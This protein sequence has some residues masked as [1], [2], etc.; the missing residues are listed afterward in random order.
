MIYRK[1]LMKIN[2]LRNRP[3]AKTTEPM[4]YFSYGMNTSPRVMAT[5]DY[6]KQVGGCILNGYH[7]SFSQFANI[8]PGG[9]MGG[10][11]WEIDHETLKD[12]DMQ[13]GYPTMYTRKV[14]PVTCKGKA[15]K[16]IIYI[17][18]PEYQQYYHEASPSKSYIKTLAAGYQAF[19][20][21]VQ[22]IKKALSDSNVTVEGYQGDIDNILLETDYPWIY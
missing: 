16:A 5:H 20:L 4:Y 14:V 10:V 7:L 21:P 6:C 11:L 19:G 8:I 13:E 12:L 3:I 2:E 15:Y 18:T 9:Q 17:M 22:Q 1:F